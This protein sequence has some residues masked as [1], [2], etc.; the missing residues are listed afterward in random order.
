M[1]LGPEEPKDWL[2]NSV[3]G[4]RLLLGQIFSTDLHSTLAPD[5]YGL[6]TQIAS[7]AVL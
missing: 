2:N 3:T 1:A 4:T 6:D 5:T 7:F